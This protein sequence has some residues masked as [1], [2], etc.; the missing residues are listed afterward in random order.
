MEDVRGLEVSAVSG[1]SGLGCLKSV[2]GYVGTGAWGVSPSAADA[3]L[4]VWPKVGTTIH[5]VL[6]EPVG[7][8]F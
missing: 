3:D 2:R 6:E 4:K 7:L 8:G 1:L 5:D